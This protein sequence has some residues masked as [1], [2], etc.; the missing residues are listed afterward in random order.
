MTFST[1]KEERKEEDFSLI[2]KCDEP[3][4]QIEMEERERERD[5][6]REREKRSGK[7]EG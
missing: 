6:Q 7:N 2:E 4:N 5:M 1:R 3:M